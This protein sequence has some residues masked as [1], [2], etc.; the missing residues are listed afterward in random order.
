MVDNTVATDGTLGEQ[1]TVVNLGWRV[2]IYTARFGQKA[3]PG[4]GRALDFRGSGIEG[5]SLSRRGVVTHLHATPG[6]HVLPVP[7]PPMP[8]RPLPEPRD[9]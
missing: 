1:Q 8:I 6:Y 4:S 3:T 9:R 5:T 7:R 2:S